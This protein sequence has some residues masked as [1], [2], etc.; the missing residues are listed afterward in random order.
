MLKAFIKSIRHQIMIVAFIFITFLGVF[1]FLF[2]LPFNAFFLGMAIIL[3]IM[4]YF[5]VDST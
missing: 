3:F 1:F 5:L 2:N 4:I